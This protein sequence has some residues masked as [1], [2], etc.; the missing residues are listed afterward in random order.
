MISTSQAAGRTSALTIASLQRLDRSVLALSGTQL[1]QNASNQILVSNFSQNTLDHGML[2]AWITIGNNFTKYGGNGVTALS[3][4]DYHTGA[5]STWAFDKNVKI[6]SSQTLTQDRNVNSL[7]IDQTGG[8][9][10]LNLGGRN[11]RV[12]SGGLMVGG[13]YDS[14]I[15]NG[16]LTAGTGTQQG[17]EL[18]IYQN[19][20]SAYTLNISANITDN[21]GYAVGVTKAGSG[22]LILS[23]QN[24]FTGGLAV[25]SGKVTLA[26]GGA[27]AAG[28]D[29]VVNS[30]RFD[31]NGQNLVLGKLA[32]DVNSTS[33]VVENLGAAASMTIGSGG[34]SSSFYGSVRGAVTVT[35]TGTGTITLGG[36]NTYTGQTIVSGG[37]LRIGHANALGALGNAGNGTIVQNGATLDVSDMPRLGAPYGEYITVSGHGVDG[38]GVITKNSAEEWNYGFGYLFLDGDVTLNSSGGRFDVEAGGSDARGHSITKIGGSGLTFDGTMANLGNLYSKQSSIQFAGAADMG[39]TNDASGHNFIY[40]LTN[41]GLNFWDKQS[42]AKGVVLRGGSMNRNGSSATSVTGSVLDVTEGLYIEA[43][44]SELRSS[45]SA[46][47][48][49]LNAINRSV[50][51]TLNVVS[52]SSTLA[53]TTSQNVNGIIGGYA[54]HGGSTWAVGSTNGTA[55]AITGLALTRPAP[56]PATGLRTRTSVWEQRLGDRDAVDQLPPPHGGGYGDHRN[57]QYPDH[58][59]GRSLGDRLWSHPDHRRHL[60]G[61]FWEGPDHHPERVCGSDD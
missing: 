16:T 27:L 33:G 15:S 11:L 34:A 61:G 12:E 39:Y 26:A 38:L 6:T 50:G 31:F 57:H 49:Q 32:S 46:Q 21:A 59:H 44:N 8:G 53:T 3:G 55:S 36:N 43:G 1:G 37:I 4:S 14:S 9:A 51:A 58:Q 60:G 45:N 35:K 5:E 47:V 13:A 24:T 48:F 54:T 18:I 7:N 17:G 28:N 40:V 25:Q 19:S 10:N 22:N 52:T 23:G 29:L 41:T 2:Q 56:P 20:G 42:D 30:G